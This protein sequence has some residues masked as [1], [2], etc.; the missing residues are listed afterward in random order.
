MSHEPRRTC[1]AC[2]QVRGKRELVRLV[3][4][5]EG[6]VFVD[7]RG[8]APGRGGYV[9]GAADCDRVALVWLLAEEEARYKSGQRV[10]LLPSAAAKLRVQ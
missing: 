6:T 9:C 10:F 7:V 4:R 3:R 2:R 1:V 5:A 8:D